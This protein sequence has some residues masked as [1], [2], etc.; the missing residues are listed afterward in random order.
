MSQGFDS[1]TATTKA[2]AQAYRVV[3][4][5]ASAMSFESSFWVMSAIVF[6]LVPLPFIM[7][8]PKPGMRQATGAH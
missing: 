4:A 1:A 6:C 8:R 3:Q 5:Q 7:R 2:L